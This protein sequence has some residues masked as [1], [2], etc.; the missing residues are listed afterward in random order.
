MAVLMLTLNLWWDGLNFSPP[1]QY[2]DYMSIKRRLRGNW[3]QQSE[4]ALERK[5]PSCL[6]S[7]HGRSM[8]DLLGFTAAQRPEVCLPLP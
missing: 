8:I 4:T 5:F 3:Q 6:I 1:P 2:I 7:E